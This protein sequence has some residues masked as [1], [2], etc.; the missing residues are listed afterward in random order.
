LIDDV[1]RESAYDYRIS[2]P[3]SLRVVANYL[4][5]TIFAVDRMSFELLRRRSKNSNTA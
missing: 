1:I 2:P 5:L 4:P 3:R